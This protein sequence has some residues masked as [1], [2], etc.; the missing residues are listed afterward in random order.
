MLN[1]TS[2][3]Y[4]SLLGYAF[5]AALVCVLC[6]IVLCVFFRK[7][8]LVIPFIGLLG[9][10]GPVTLY[11]PISTEGEVPEDA[12]QV[13]S[14]N[15]YN[16]GRGYPHQNEEA[17]EEVMQ[18]AVNTGAD[19]VCFQ[20]AYAIEPVKEKIQ[21]IMYPAYK[22]HDTILYK[23][24]AAVTLFSKFPITRKE[25]IAYETIGNVS[26]AFWLNIKGKEVIVIN[27]HLETMGFS[28]EDR[29][30]FSEMVHGNSK[31]EEMK[32]T[33]KTIFGKILDATKKRSHQA[34]AV[35]TFIRRHQSST[36]IVC[37]DFNDIPNS[38][39]HNAIIKAGH[40]EDGVTF[41]L[42]DCYQK[43][44]F[45]PGYSFSKFGMKVRIDNI[46]CSPD[47]TPHKCF[48]DNEV[49]LSDHYPIRCWMTL[50]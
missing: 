14:Y 20:E 8:L 21:R 43:K 5:P 6:S 17:P 24:G 3:G 40:L 22:Y 47:I 7:R 26:G 35:A 28:V 36:M 31:K 38:Y 15:T 27:N 45:G 33:S 50:D 42:T 1:P 39:T 9:A 44:G 32:S 2:W 23:H 48:V 11:F 10:Y 30:A 12:I 16:W 25:R 41:D 49:T 29:E 4:A 13:L 19:I 46:I 34:D 37:G 18:Y